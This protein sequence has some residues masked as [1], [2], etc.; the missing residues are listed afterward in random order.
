MET[1]LCGEKLEESAAI[2]TDL[3]EYWHPKQKNSGTEN[4]D[5]TLQEFGEKSLMPKKFRRNAGLVHLVGQQ[6]ETKRIMVVATHLMT[7]GRDNKEKNKFPG[8][9]RAGEIATLK[10]IIEEHAK[11]NEAVMLMGDFNTKPMQHNIF[12]GK[13]KNENGESI[14]EKTSFKRLVDGNWSFDWRSEKG[15][16]ALLVDAFANNHGWSEPASRKNS[17][18]FTSSNAVRREWI[19][20]VFYSPTQLELIDLSKPNIPQNPIPDLNEPSDHIPLGVKMKF[21]TGLRS[22]I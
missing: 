17:N 22:K 21:K 3:M 11:P 9:V 10:K 6:D 8:E 16:G 15:T 19:D 13:I 5:D 4:D 7:T 12:S 1:I 14:H 20:Y 2:N 18:Q